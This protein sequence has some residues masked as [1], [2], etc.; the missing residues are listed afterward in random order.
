MQTY[1][2]GYLYHY[3]PTYQDFARRLALVGGEVDIYEVLGVQFN[4]DPASLGRFAQHLDRPISLHSYE[5]AL[6]DV[7]RPRPEV[8]D[9]I[10]RLID[11]GNI[12]YVGEHIA[13]MGTSKHYLGAFM[14]PF[15]TDEQTQA[16][17]DNVNHAKKAMGVPI[18]LENPS[19]FHNVVGSRTI[20]QQMRALL[21]ETDSGLLLSFS[22]IS[23]S[24]DFCPQDREAFLAELPLERVREFHVLCNNSV[25]ERMA[26]REQARYEQAWALGM[27]EEMAKRPEVRPSAVVFELEAGTDAMCEPER[28]RDFMDMARSLFFSDSAARSEQGGNN[29]AR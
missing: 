15:G 28:L 23:I 9:R 7:D 17:I 10:K 1:G 3:D 16:L 19:Q 8:I 22:N 4:G 20:G 13:Y 6:G 27:L 14:Q 12:A 25:E 18:I 5:I 2:A 29:G 11:V 26:G 24:E 21:E